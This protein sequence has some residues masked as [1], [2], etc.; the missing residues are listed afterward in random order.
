MN[1]IIPMN[2]YLLVEVLEPS[3]SEGVYFGEDK[4]KPKE[5]KILAFSAECK[6]KN[7]E[8]GKTV[9]INKYEMIPN[10][11]SDT[12]FFVSEKAIVAMK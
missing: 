1:E 4:N 11:D 5:G 3:K 6:N 7:F 2:D 12:E 9:V 8:K 10:G